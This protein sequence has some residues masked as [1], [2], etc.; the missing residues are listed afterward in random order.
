MTTNAR[1]HAL[2]FAVIALFAACSEQEPRSDVALQSRASALDRQHRAYDGG[3]V[4]ADLIFP[5]GVGLTNVA[6]A[7]RGSLALGEGATILAIDGSPGEVSDA[8]QDKDCDGGGPAVFL[9]DRVTVGTVVSVGASRFV[10]T[11]RRRSCARARASP[12]GATIPSVRLR[13]A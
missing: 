12:W 11:T 10:T 7:A 6:L 2:G 13:R 3:T 9:A 5:A 4:S 8:T 1:P